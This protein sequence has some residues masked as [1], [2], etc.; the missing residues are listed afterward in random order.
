MARSLDELFEVGAKMVLK[1]S[2]MPTVN[3]Y[4]IPVP[5]MHADTTS[6]TLYGAYEDS[7]EEDY[8]IHLARELSPAQAIVLTSIDLALILTIKR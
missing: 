1:E 6:K 8:A 2:C 5:S 7:V 3:E 4:D